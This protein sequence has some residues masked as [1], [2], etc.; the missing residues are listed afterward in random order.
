MYI[1]LILVQ[2]DII[3]TAKATK[4]LVMLEFTK[5]N[6]RRRAKYQ[7][8]SKKYQKGSCKIYYEDSGVVCRN[9][10]ESSIEEYLPD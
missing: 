1:V 5:P 8:L 2:S 6:C 9:S 3:I 4:Q 7:E 10:A